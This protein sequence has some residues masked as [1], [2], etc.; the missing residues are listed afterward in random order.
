MPVNSRFLDSCP[1]VSADGLLLF[2]LSLRFGG[3]GQAD[4][5]VSTRLT[6]DDPWSTPLNLGPN[7]NTH[8]V[9][10]YP[11]ISFDGRLFMFVADKPDGV[12][13]LDIWQ[14]EITA[15]PVGSLQKDS[16]VD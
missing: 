5:Y 10:E 1:D 2:F 8:N 11:K 14:V 15:M 13:Q 7:V 16:N 3:L 4:L 6:T 9:E 12:G